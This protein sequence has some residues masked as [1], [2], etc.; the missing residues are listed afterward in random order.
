MLVVRTRAPDRYPPL[1]SAGGY[2]RRLL[3]TTIDRLQERASAGADARFSGRAEARPA[4]AVQRSAG[5]CS[6]IRGGRMTVLSVLDA[7][8]QRRS[9]ATIP[10]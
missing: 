2:S 8:R 10:G 5:I 3:R 4:S 1:R 9:P 6:P 7:A